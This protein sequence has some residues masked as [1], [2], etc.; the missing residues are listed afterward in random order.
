MTAPDQER[1][2]VPPESNRCRGCGQHCGERWEATG[3]EHLS[4]RPDSLY[5]PECTASLIEAEA[6]ADKA[7]VIVRELRR[8]SDAGS[9]RAVATVDV[10]PWTIRGCRVIEQAGHAA[11]VVLP[12]ERT[13]K[14]RFFPVLTITNQRLQ[15]RLEAAVLARYAGRGTDHAKIN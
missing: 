6:L 12:Q 15:A 13:H 14:G 7:P 5:C 3:E 2:Q 8:L 10:G 1:E 4:K 11:Y 9:L